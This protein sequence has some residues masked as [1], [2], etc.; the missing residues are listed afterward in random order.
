NICEECG[1]PNTVADLAD[2]VAK[3]SGGTP[4]AGTARRYV[5]PLHE[6]ADAVFAHHRQGRVPARLRELPAR[7][8][9]RGR[10]AIPRPHPGDWG[11]TPDQPDGAGQVIWVWPEMAFGFLHGIERLGERLGRDWTAAAPADDWK[12]VHFFGYD[13]SFYHAILYPLLYRFALP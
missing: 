5:L 9:R 13:N 1:E 10:V 7:L 11:I 2:P 6:H 8:F 12:I 4:T 3:P